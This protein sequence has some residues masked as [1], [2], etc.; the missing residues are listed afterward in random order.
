MNVVEGSEQEKI[1]WREKV[2]WTV[3]PT[4][5]AIPDTQQRVTLVIAHVVGN[6]VG[7]ELDGGAHK[8]SCAVQSV[9]YAVGIVAIAI[10]LTI[11]EGFDT[12]RHGA[13]MPGTERNGPWNRN[14]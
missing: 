9:K 3:R 11:S 7:T 4:I 13:V 14:T 8:P 1:D 6:T 5:A 2:R 12:S 10:A